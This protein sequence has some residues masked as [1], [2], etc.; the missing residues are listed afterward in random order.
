MAL[1]S[2]LDQP[3]RTMGAEFE[4]AVPLVGSGNLLDVQRQI[5]GILSANGI[6]ANFRGYSHAPVLDC[7]IMVE[8]DSS[9]HGDGR[10]AGITWIP[11][12]VKTRI[13]HGLADYMQ[14]VPKT[15]EILRALNCRVNASTGHHLHIGIQEINSDPTI[16]RSLYNLIHRIEPSLYMVVS[17]S[18]R[19]SSYSRPLPDV[20]KL[21]HKCHKLECFERALSH[22][23]RYQGLNWHGL[24][25]SDGAPRVEYRYHGGTLDTTKALHWARLCTQIINHACARSCQAASKQLPPTKEGLRKMLTTIGLKINT[26]VYSK[27][28]PELRETGR[29]FLIKRWKELNGT[30]NQPSRSPVESEG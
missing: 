15:L 11:L 14:I 6:R 19:S 2:R 7:D 23:E 24:F 18:R 1:E 21:L 27:V 8:T 30:G 29:Y 22:L 16:I 17:P 4:C 3:I 9:V 28:A 25:L 13:M 26:K 10:I 5:S 12:E 20:S